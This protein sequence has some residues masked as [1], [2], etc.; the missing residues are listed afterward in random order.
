MS[1]WNRPMTRYQPAPAPAKRGRELERIRPGLWRDLKTARL[2][3]RNEDGSWQVMF[4][5]THGMVPT[6]SLRFRTMR[7]AVRS[8][9]TVN[10]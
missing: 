8:L 10:G 6:N 5:T 9:R 7:A 1:R 4:D 3:R 2:L